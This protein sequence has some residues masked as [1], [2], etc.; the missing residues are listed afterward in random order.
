M[1]LGQRVNAYKYEENGKTIQLADILYAMADLP[2]LERLKQGVMV[3]SFFILA[4][5]VIPQRYRATRTAKSFGTT[6][7]DLS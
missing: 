1:L 5:R 7:G 4:T 2:G 3:I 6:K